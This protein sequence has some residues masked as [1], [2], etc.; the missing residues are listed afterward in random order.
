MPMSSNISMSVEKAYAMC[1]AHREKNGARIFSQYWGCVRYSREV[2][3][4]MCFYKPPNNDACRHVNQM[5]E[6]SNKQ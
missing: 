4:K 6:R 2:P 3:E 1:K 5:Y